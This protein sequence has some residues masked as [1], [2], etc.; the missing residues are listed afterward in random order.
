MS[1]ILVWLNFEVFLAAFLPT[2]QN[3]ACD[4]ADLKKCEDWLTFCI[5]LRVYNLCGKFGHTLFF[6]LLFFLPPNKLGLST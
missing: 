5:P 4:F 2:L 3:P 6:F 1:G